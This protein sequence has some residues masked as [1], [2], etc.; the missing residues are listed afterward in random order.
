M[1]MP[2]SISPAS[3][4]NYVCFITWFISF[5]LFSSCHVV[6]ET[7]TESQSIDAIIKYDGSYTVS[8]ICNELHMANATID[9]LNGTIEGE[10]IHNLN[11]QTFNVNGMVTENGRLNIQ[12]ITTETDEL[13]EVMGSID[14]N[15]MIQGTYQV[16]HRNCKFIGFCFSK[17]KNEIVTQYD[18]TYQLNLISDGN[19]VASFKAS[20][21]H[22]KF[23]RVITN[24]NQNSYTIDGKVSKNGRLI[25]NTLFSNLNNGVT[26]I[27]CIQSDGSV[28]G[29]YNTY[30]GKKGAFS[31][32]KISE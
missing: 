12:A 13:V 11:Q 30:N 26:V 28:I 14:N 23:H 1:A 25:M 7:E 6:P 29:I 31:G 20:I 17:N 2:I 5:L 24:I 27:G 4:A 21:E 22:G 19:N 18:G 16:G 15:G 32:K 9:I 8:F 10:I 3:I